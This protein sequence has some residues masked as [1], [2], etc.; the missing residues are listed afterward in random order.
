MVDLPIEWLLE[1]SLVDPRRHLDRERVQRYSQ[2][3]DE[4]PPVTVFRL[5][6]EALLLVDGYHRVA[7]AQ[8]RGRATVIADL[9]VGTRADAVAFAAE[10]ARHERGVS[11]QRA[12][13]AI[14]RHSNGRWSTEER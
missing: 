9:R 7:A 2:H 6:D 10:N 8:A 3:L 1:S 4:L 12:R 13:A 5:D 14:Q 11:S